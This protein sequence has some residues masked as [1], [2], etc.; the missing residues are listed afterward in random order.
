V[1]FICGP[2]D[3]CFLLSEQ[4][5]L[6]MPF[7]FFDFFHSKKSEENMK[8][9]MILHVLMLYGQVLGLWTEPT[10]KL[11]KNQALEWRRWVSGFGGGEGEGFG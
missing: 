5:Q 1:I 3:F 11:I 2:S 10:C 8:P 6:D 9:V 4:W 7:Y